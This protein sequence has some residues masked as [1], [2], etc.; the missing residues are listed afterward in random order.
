MSD[1]GRCCSPQSAREEKK[2]NLG[3]PEFVSPSKDL[4]FVVRRTPKK[5]KK[6]ERCERKCGITVVSKTYRCL[7]GGLLPSAAAAD[8]LGIGIQMT[9]PAAPISLVPHQ[10]FG[11]SG[12][13]D[14]IPALQTQSLGR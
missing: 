6:N 10:C 12:C 14:C 7:R 11:R 2:R 4:V 3:A 13:H 5:E 8:A 9:A 1:N